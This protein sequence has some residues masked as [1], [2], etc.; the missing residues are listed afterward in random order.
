MVLVILISLV[1][2]GSTAFAE[3]R[4]QYG[5]GSASAALAASDRAK[6]YD[7]LTVLNNPTLMSEQYVGKVTFGIFGAVDSFTPASNIVVNNTTLGAGSRET[8]NVST[9]VPDVFLTKLG[10][11]IA[12]GKSESHYRLGI[13]L[14][15]PVERVAGP[16]SQ[17][18]YTPQY[19]I[20][21][22][23]SQ[24]MVLGTG[25]SFKPLAQLSVGFGGQLYMTSGATVTTKLPQQPATSRVNQSTQVQPSFGPQVGLLFIPVPHHRISLSWAMERDY[26][27]DFESKNSV[28][29]IGGSAPFNFTGSQSLFYDPEVWSAAYCLE[30]GR[31][32][33]HATVDYERWSRF[34]GQMVKIQFDTFQG[35]FRQL[36]PDTQYHDIV[37][38]RVGTQVRINQN[39]AVRAGYAFRPSPV[40]DL[41]GETNFL[42]S[43]RHVFAAGHAWKTPWNLGGST[44]RMDWHMQ[45]HHL[46]R[47]EVVKRSQDYVGAAASSGGAPMVVEGNVF[48]YGLTVSVDI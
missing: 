9:D 4:S 30:V 36:Q 1:F 45:L 47:K 14:L 12:I 7:G 41:S 44:L 48:S 34:D 25:F 43:D 39:H 8:G 5:V 13:G 31:V 15:M 27:L 10:A 18:Y 11:T 33:L 40:P 29:L 42:D 21:N 37:V 26:R 32:D 3:L 38:P 24:R 22:A 16:N 17:D 19:A 28:Y 20:Y 46:V 35:S 6:G 2:S 23:D